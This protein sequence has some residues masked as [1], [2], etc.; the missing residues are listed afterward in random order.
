[1]GNL[2]YD[3]RTVNT[4]LKKVVGL[5]QRAKQIGE[6][7]RNNPNVKK[8]S[9]IEVIETLGADADREIQQRNRM[10]SELASHA[11]EL[12]EELERLKA[13]EGLP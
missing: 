8:E 2:T 6:S 5:G 7:I 12:R 3:E 11:D 4:M 10:I 1:M 9:L 13:S